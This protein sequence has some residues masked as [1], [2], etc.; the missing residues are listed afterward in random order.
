MRL[1]LNSRLKVYEGGPHGLFITHMD[2]FN[3]DLLAFIKGE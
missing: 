2:R 3:N 1:I